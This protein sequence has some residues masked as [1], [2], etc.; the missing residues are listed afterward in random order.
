MGK[1]QFSLHVVEP[2]VTR[3]YKPSRENKNAIKHDCMIRWTYKPAHK[4]IKITWLW[5]IYA[6]V[7]LNLI[8]L[9]LSCILTSPSIMSTEIFCLERHQSE[10]VHTVLSA[11]LTATS[12][13][14][15]TRLLS[16]TA[17]AYLCTKKNIYI[18]SYIYCA[19]FEK[20]NIY[21]VI[22]INNCYECIK[23]KIVI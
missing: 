19:H 14:S 2:I 18:L 4:Q 7:S 8:M 17:E 12:H 23:K 13:S 21:L 11:E 22:V 3:S 15:L 10:R 6:H 5:A 16:S 20:T 1:W 9:S